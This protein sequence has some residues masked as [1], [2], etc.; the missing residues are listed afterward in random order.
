[1]N[2]IKDASRAGGAGRRK[3]IKLAIAGDRFARKV[4]G[5]DRLKMR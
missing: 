1:L 3:I 2:S 5:S 4:R